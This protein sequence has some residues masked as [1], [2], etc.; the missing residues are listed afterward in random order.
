M[1]SLIPCRLKFS[2]ICTQFYFSPWLSSFLDFNLLI[3]GRNTG[4]SFNLHVGTTANSTLSCYPSNQRSYRSTYPCPRSFV[5]S[6]SRT[7]DL[8]FRHEK[9]KKNTASMLVSGTHTGVARDPEQFHV[10]Q[11]LRLVM[12]CD[13]FMYKHG[14]TPYKINYLRTQQFKKIKPLKSI[15]WNEP[16]KWRVL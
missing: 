2:K 5:Q 12:V 6:S 13:R 9:R 15:I 11:L 16:R 7:G 3:R 14:I 4:V 10:L 1:T 8:V